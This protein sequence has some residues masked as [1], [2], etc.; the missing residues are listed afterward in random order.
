MCNYE[1][2]AEHPVEVRGMCWAGSEGCALKLRPALLGMGSEGKLQ[3]GMK[4]PCEYLEFPG[5]FFGK[6]RTSWNSRTPRSRKAQSVHCLLIKILH[7][8]VKGWKKGEGI[9][10]TAFLLGIHINLSSLFLSPQFSESADAT[11]SLD[12]KMGEER[13]D[14]QTLLW[15]QFC[16]CLFGFVLWILLGV[17]LG[18]RTSFL[19]AFICVSLN[20]QQ[21][22]IPWETE[23]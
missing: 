22:E 2:T 16:C 13:S 5:P 4:F 17:C 20:W 8:D 14:G 18:Q 3:G 9:L 19:C 1:P 10:I 21:Q 6:F 12:F 23:A 15:K 7:L 11:F